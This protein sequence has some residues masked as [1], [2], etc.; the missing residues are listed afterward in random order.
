MYTNT[1]SYNNPRGN[2]QNHYITTWR[3][4]SLLAVALMFLFP[5]P[6]P[7]A[8]TTELGDIQGTVI[9]KKF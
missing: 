6:T 3:M 9:D 5:L 4:C 8:Q 7:Y 2:S 1:S